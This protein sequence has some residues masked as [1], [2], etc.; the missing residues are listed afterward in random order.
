MPQQSIEKQ[1]KVYSYFGEHVE[2]SHSN[3]ENIKDTLV[4]DW[5]KSQTVYAD[6]IVKKLAG[7]SD[8]IE[9]YEQ[10]DNKKYAKPRF[11]KITFNNKHFFLREDSVDAI[12]KLFYKD[13]YNGDEV[14]LFDP[15]KTHLDASINYIQPN[16][17]GSKIVV[18]LTKKGAE[19]GDMYI[20][21]VLKNT[22]L[23][24]V[25]PNCWPSALEGVTWLTNNESFIYSYIPV[26]DSKS[27]DFILNTESLLYTIGDNP[28]DHN[29][30][31][32][33]THN[34]NL[35]IVAGDFPFASIRNQNNKYI[36]GRIGGARNFD[37]Y[38]YATNYNIAQI[39]WKPLYRKEDKIREFVLDDNDNLFFLTAKNASNYKIGVTSLKNPDF[40]AYKTL[41]EEDSTSVITD[42]VLT[43]DG[44]FFVKTK[45]GVQAKLFRLNNTV[46]EEISI[47]KASGNIYLSSNGSKFKQLWIRIEGWTNELERYE[48]NFES[49]TFINKSNYSSSINVNTKDFVVEEIEVPSY[50]GELVPLSIIYKKG[51]QLEAKNRI[52][53]T[54]YGAY[55]IS[56]SPYLDKYMYHWVNNGGIYAIAHVRGGGEKGDKWHKGGQKLTKPNSWKDFIA[57]TEYLINKKYSSPDKI[58]VWSASAGGILIGRAVTERPDLYAAA[59]IQVGILN[60]LRNE[61]AA[62]GQ[63][64]IK[65]FG[66]VKDSLGF[67]ALYEMDSYHHI[68]EGISYPAM[69]LTAGLNDSRVPAWQAAKFTARM[70]DASTSNKPILLSVDFEGGHGMD[71]SD[72]KQKNELAN[73]LT[74]ALWQTGHP[75]YQPK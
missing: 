12:Y 8:I 75:D 14:L 67:K 10:L 32:S 22:V 18:N 58:A 39:N 65:E 72:N 74:F 20:I 23:K 53:M 62:N 24:E 57:C 51:M 9:A 28:K 71:S 45:N 48:Y 73:A 68:K 29:V 54:G 66:T 7:R 61:F 6:K 49:N 56:D 33:R 11:L 4:L 2:D 1:S 26:I 16:Y 69:Y 5:F 21:D 47:P 64:G 44:L 52:L 30:L 55:G 31:L 15:S 13:G 40:S 34:P 27:N 3:L 41:V 43:S 63:N 19:I 17:D 35:N 42:M 50:D 38:Y 46:V 37:D 25:L 60:T 59:I 70:L 36:F